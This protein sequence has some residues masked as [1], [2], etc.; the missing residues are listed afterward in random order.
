MN[1]IR[2]NYWATQ[3]KVTSPKNSVVLLNK[4][5]LENSDNEIEYFSYSPYS[6]DLDNPVVI[7]AGARYLHDIV[8]QARN[9]LR[10]KKVMSRAVPGKLV[11]D[12]LPASYFEHLPFLEQSDLL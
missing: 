4:Y 7:Q 8:D 1:G 3:Y 12:T 11:V 6:D 5:P 9:D 2:W 10:K